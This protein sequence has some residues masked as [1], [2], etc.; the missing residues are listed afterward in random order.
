[1]TCVAIPAGSEEVAAL[2]DV[3]G[4]GLR[5]SSPDIVVSILGTWDERG[6]VLNSLD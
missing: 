3:L 1:M 4:Y 6:M 5:E 2:V